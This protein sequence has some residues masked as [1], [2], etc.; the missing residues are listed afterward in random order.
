MH[1]SN[2]SY[3]ESYVTILAEEV[4]VAFGSIRVL[5]EAEL[6]GACRDPLEEG[7]VQ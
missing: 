3:T 1:Y 7:G 6:V 2:T 5:S 4:S